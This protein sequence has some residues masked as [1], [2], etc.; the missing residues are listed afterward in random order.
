MQWCDFSPCSVWCPWGLAV[1]SFG[2]HSALPLFF[3]TVPSAGSWAPAGSFTLGVP[4]AWASIAWALHSS[5]SERDACQSHTCAAGASCESGPAGASAC[6]ASSSV[7]LPSIL[8]LPGANPSQL[9]PNAWP[10]PISHSVMHPLNIC[11]VP[12]V[13]WSQHL[14]LTVWH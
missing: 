8:C 6:Y 7:H 4:Q 11:R 12:P 5:Y 2:T 3:V 13:C 14:V 10:S 9:A 1:P